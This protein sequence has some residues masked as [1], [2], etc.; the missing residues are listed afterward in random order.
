MLILGSCNPKSTSKQ[1]GNI[2]ALKLLDFPIIK[3]SADFI[4]TLKQT[5]NIESDI[6]NNNE[7]ITTFKKVKIYGSNNEFFFI[8]FDYEAGCMATYPW[9]YQLL[10]TI[11]GKLVKILSAQRYD[12]VQ[13][14]PNENPFLLAVIATSKGN[15]GHEIYKVSADT[16]ENVYEGYYDYEV[17]TYDAH[18]DFAVYEPYELNFKIKDY[19]N[20]GFNDIAFVGKKNLIQGRTEDGFWYDT[21][22]MNGKE[23]AAYSINN[24][25]KKIPIE[26]IF[27]YDKKTGHFKAKENYVK[28]IDFFN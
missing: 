3:D 28:N 16:L 12:F 25:F 4:S 13:I 10:L 5:Y 27:L 18:G 21:E 23:V 6:G 20:D 9:K 15:G 7:Q 1:D 22:T 8:E 14:F 24:P 26:F 17:Q 11:D 19:N 2:F